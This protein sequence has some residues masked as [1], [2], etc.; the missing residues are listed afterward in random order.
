[1]WRVV[2][3]IGFEINRIVPDQTKRR[4]P[5]VAALEI[6]PRTVACDATA[7]AVEANGRTQVDVE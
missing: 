4:D 6:W 5:S 1:M 7:I 3:G 2:S